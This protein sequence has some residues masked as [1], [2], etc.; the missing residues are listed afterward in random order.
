MAIPEID[1]NVSTEAT[2]C[3]IRNVPEY[4]LND[5]DCEQNWSIMEGDT[6]KAIA[7]YPEKELDG[8]ASS[9]THDSVV[10]KNPHNLTWGMTCGQYQGD[11]SASYVVPSGDTVGAGQNDQASVIIVSV[12]IPLV[13]LVLVVALLYLCLSRKC[14]EPQETEE[15]Q[16]YRM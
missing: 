10:L 4:H 9:V 6:T 2:K 7:M 5:P 15:P 13:I 12:C 11:Y 8:C 3:T 14:K 1:C 16:E